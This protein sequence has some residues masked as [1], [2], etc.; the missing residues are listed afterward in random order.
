MKRWLFQVVVHWIYI[1]QSFPQGQITFSNINMSNCLYSIFNQSHSLCI[2]LCAFVN[3]FSL[4]G[5]LVESDGAIQIND[6][7]LGLLFY[8]SGQDRIDAAINQSASGLSIRSLRGDL[9]LNVGDDGL[10]PTR[11]FISGN[12][13]RIG[14]GTTQPYSLMDVHGT[15]TMTGAS[16]LF[17][18]ISST[19]FSFLGPSLPSESFQ[20][21][22]ELPIDYSSDIHTF[23]SGSTI[24]MTLEPNQ[25]EVAQNLH[26]G[27]DS[28]IFFVDGSILPAEISWNGNDLI[29]ENTE[30]SESNNRIELA[31]ADG[32][33]FRSGASNTTRIKVSRDGN[34]SL[35]PEIGDA[36]FTLD[37]NH[38]EGSPSSD[39]N[40][41][42]NIANT[43]GNNNQWQL[44]VRNGGGGDLELFKNRS[45]RGQ[46][47]ATSGIY[48][49]SSD[50][51]L[52]KNIKPLKNQL[53]L[54]MQ[55]RPT[56]YLF[57]DQE[58]ERQNYGLIAQ[59]VQEILP[60][61]VRTMDETKREIL[62]GLSYTE[63]IPIVIAAMQEQ[64]IIITNLKSQNAELLHRIER[65]EKLIE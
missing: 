22:S 6:A 31:S 59:E 51:R 42:L 14:I 2:I 65:L 56:T 12:Q 16:L 21:A 3:I 34:V 35:G 13:G 64:Q 29:I 26:I 55:L 11:L 33:V 39:A 53:E 47:D 41:G 36:D 1:C 27:D 4:S 54:V 5:Q 50:R 8:D 37:I 58:S 20:V 24:L 52:K 15:L 10:A 49:T 46:F 57:K 7:D 62:Y 28:G 43:G 38:G 30:D 40:H 45:L 44:Y 25:I 19:T 9:R 18:D 61:I 48:S 17:R 23:S 32:F 60:D 63:F